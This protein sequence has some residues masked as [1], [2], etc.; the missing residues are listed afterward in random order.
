MDDEKLQELEFFE[1]NILIV[2]YLSNRSITKEIAKKLVQER[3]DFARGKEI[4]LIMVFPQLSNMDKGGRD[5]LS[6]EDAKEGVLA[7]AMVVNTVIGKVIMNFFLK[8]NN[9]GNDDVP[10][11]VCHTVEE[12]IEWIKKYP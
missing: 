10:N 12:A 6:S 7:S 5:Y 11:K 3:K 8:L 9:K 4:K 1:N 2:R